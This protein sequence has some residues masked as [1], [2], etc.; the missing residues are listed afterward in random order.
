MSRSG[1]VI[2]AMR[3][4]G[5]NR[6]LSI[7]FSLLTGIPVLLAACVF[8]IY[9]IINLSNLNFIK[10]ILYSYNFIFFSNNN[11]TFFLQMDRKIFFQNIQHL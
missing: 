2:T 9:K 5:I 3:F 6:K 7:T 11:Y 1:T 4:L 8:G 10:L